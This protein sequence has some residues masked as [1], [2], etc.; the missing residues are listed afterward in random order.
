MNIILV[1]SFAPSVLN[2]RGPL[3]RE[4]LARGHK[5]AVGAPDIPS[6]VRQELEVLG[7]DVHETPLLRNTT[8][9]FAD[10]AYLKALTRLFQQERPDLVLTYT[11]KPNIW[12]ALAAAR[13]KVPSVAMVTGLGFVFMD[14]DVNW[15]MRVS[16][17][18]ARQ[19]YRIATR[20]NRKVIFQNPDDRDDFLAAGCLADRSKIAMVDGS[21]VDMAHFA[22]API[23]SRPV[24]LMIARLLKSKGVQEY[25]DAARRIRAQY[26]DAHFLLVGPHDSGPDA[27]DSEEVSHWV[28]EGVLDWRG[29]MA[30]VRPAISEAAIYVLPSY[31]EGTPRSVLEAMAMGRPII[32]S[33]APGCRE[34]IREGVEGFL[35]PVRDAD[36]LA[37]AMEKFIVDP[38]LISRM[39]D[40][41]FDRACEKYDVNKINQRMVEHLGL[42]D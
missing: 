7:V 3:I 37:R 30:D 41:A 29:G 40:A 31:R 13:A 42:I 11:I 14:T 24:F 34:T 22:R 25:A 15:K 1:A 6:E 18:L 10:L 39:G 2:F 27:V 36:A 5:V 33:D 16:R 28:T 21:G 38:A 20:F 26:P 35:V 8:G 32:T 17:W 12:G 9:V 19:L 4:L 23:V